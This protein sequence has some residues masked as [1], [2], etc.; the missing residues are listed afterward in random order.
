VPKNRIRAIFASPHLPLQGTSGQVT[1]GI[2][3]QWNA[4]IMGYGKILIDRK[5]NR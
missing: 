1:I 2:M 5:I 3:E 4:G